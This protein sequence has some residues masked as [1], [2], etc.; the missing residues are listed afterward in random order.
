LAGA[1]PRHVLPAVNVERLASPSRCRVCERCDLSHE[2]TWPA[3]CAAAAPALSRSVGFL[4]PSPMSLMSGLFPAMLSLF[5]SG[6]Q[7]EITIASCGMYA[8]PIH[9]VAC[10]ADAALLCTQI[11]RGVALT[12]AADCRSTAQRLHGRCT[13]CTSARGHGQ[14]SAHLRSRC[15]PRFVQEQLSLARL[16]S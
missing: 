12:S 2:H 14:F 8:W 6:L 16:M 13:R 15:S 3:A 9:S 5:C 11:L 10:T 4:S 7:A 1:Q